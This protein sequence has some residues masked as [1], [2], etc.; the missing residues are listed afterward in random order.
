MAVDWLACNIF[1]SLACLIYLFHK[2]KLCYKRCYP[3]R[4]FCY[5]FLCSPISNRMSLYLM[6]SFIFG[7]LAEPEPRLTFSSD[8]WKLS[9]TCQFQSHHLEPLFQ[10]WIHREVE[11]KPTSRWASWLSTCS[12]SI[13]DYINIMIV[14]KW[15]G[16]N[17]NHTVNLEFIS[18]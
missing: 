1:V 5:F 3:G 4:H 2:E 17:R 13:C 15:H 6:S 10:L 7:V 14:Q 18:F 12:G 8:E 16:L 9:D 11:D